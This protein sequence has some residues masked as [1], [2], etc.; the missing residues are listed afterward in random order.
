MEAVFVSTAVFWVSACH[1][2]GG[3]L[4]LTR[5]PYDSLV[6]TARHISSLSCVCV[7]ALVFASFDT[8]VIVVV[9]AAIKSGETTSWGHCL[10]SMTASKPLPFRGRTVASS[11]HF[12]TKDREDSKPVMFSIVMGSVALDGERAFTACLS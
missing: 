1:S 5:V 7:F 8:H 4:V 9:V 11:P 10:V 2:S 3:W 12:W 6:S